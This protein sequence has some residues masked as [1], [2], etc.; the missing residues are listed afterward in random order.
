M[1]KRITAPAF[2]GGTTEVTFDYTSVNAR[3]F[4]LI[5]DWEAPF[6][7]AIHAYPDSET[8]MTWSFNEGTDNKAHKVREFGLPTGAVI[9]YEYSG[10]PSFEVCREV[11]RDP[12]DE[13]DEFFWRSSVKKRTIRS[14]DA[15]QTERVETT[16]FARNMNCL[17]N[18]F[19]GKVPYPA[20]PVFPQ[21]NDNMEK[22][23][24]VWVETYSGDADPDDD[25]NM[26]TTSTAEIHRF[27]EPN[28]Q[29][30]SV[31]YLST[32]PASRRTEIENGIYGNYSTPRDESVVQGWDDVEVLRH[33]QTHRYT[34][35][36]DDENQIYDDIPCCPHPW[37]YFDN[38]VDWTATITNEDSEVVGSDVRNCKSLKG[39]TAPDT[40]QEIRTSLAVNALFRPMHNYA[41]VI[42]P[43]DA[44]PGEPDK[45]H[46]LNTNSYTEY[47]FD[48]PYTEVDST[49][50]DLGKMTT[51]K[52]CGDPSCSSWVSGLCETI[53]CGTWIEESGYRWES[54]DEESGQD[55]RPRRLRARSSNALP[56][57]GDPAQWECPD[58]E[59]GC[60]LTIFNYDL[61]GNQY[62]NSK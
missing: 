34:L 1:L 57:E 7:T 3:P 46:I 20:S 26:K 55:F 29:E 16:A 51:E 17:S 19:G 25:E 53:S 42:N 56:P 31:D 18:F 62:R 47:S 5:Q 27:N 60:V 48:S 15:S 39:D 22:Y 13:V 61:L 28:F 6:L 52:V 8:T 40:C 21:T 24:W 37:E 23:R 10:N 38:V 14:R 35:F 32:I 44:D 50:W 11:V 49:V 4:G 45:T 12:L 9:E 2:E 41:E 58:P 33:T 43:L 54:A 30:F 36:G 59:G